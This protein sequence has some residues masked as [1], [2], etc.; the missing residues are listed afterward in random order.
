MIEAPAE[1]YRGHAGDSLAFRVRLP[2]GLTVR[3]LEWR[4]SFDGERTLAEGTITDPAAD[5]TLKG[6]LA[7]PGF[8]RLNLTAFT[9]SDT[10]RA[11][12][13][14]AVDPEA[15]TPTVHAPEDWQLFWQHGLAELERVAMDPVV[16]PWPLSPE[17]SGLTCYRVSLGCIEGSRVWGWLTIP[18]GEG[19]FPAVLC[20]QG[21]PGGLGEYA[22][23]PQREYARAGMVVLAVNPHGLELGR[24]DTSYYQRQLGREVPGPAALLGADD[25]YRYYYRRVVLGAV[26][27]IDYLSGRSDVDTTRLAVAGAS[28]GGGL[29]LLTAAVDRRVK[30]LTVHVPAMCDYGGRCMAVPPAGRNWSSAGRGTRRMRCAPAAISM[31]R[32]RRSG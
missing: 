28:Q 19:P 11:A 29:S 32:W 3:R 25:P 23:Y 30:A 4:F 12:G 26:R 27:A 13:A 5:L 8:L 10:L 21:A 1:G 17:D 16:E 24:P 22:T 6:A 14:R 2:A 7:E 9:V 18:A 31:P 15:I 20:Q